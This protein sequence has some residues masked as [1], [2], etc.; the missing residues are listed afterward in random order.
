MDL[1]HT[2][3]ALQYPIICPVPC[4]CPLRVSKGWVDR[5]S[6]QEDV[7]RIGYIEAPFCTTHHK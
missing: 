3:I 1:M 2:L 4:T 7:I 6:C 5:K